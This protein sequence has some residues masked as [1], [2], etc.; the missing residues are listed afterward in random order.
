M[1]DMSEAKAWYSEFKAEDAPRLLRERLRPK[2]WEPWSGEGTRLPVLGVSE[3]VI[4]LCFRLQQS[5][6]WTD[7]VT[8][9]VIAHSLA[10]A[11]DA[12]HKQLLEAMNHQMVKPFVHDGK[13]VVF[14]GNAARPMYDALKVVVEDPGLPPSTR[15]TV[16]GAIAKAEDR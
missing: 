5:Q 9:A 6:G 16:E 7:E 3:Q 4:T 11:M 8:F 10:E 15:A 13:R 12:Q 14:L 2:R 1:P